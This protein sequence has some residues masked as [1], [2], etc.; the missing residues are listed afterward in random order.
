MQATAASCQSAT[1]VIRFLFLFLG[2]RTQG[3]ALF[4]VQPTHEGGLQLGRKRSTVVQR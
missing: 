4:Y 2:A 3:V 1:F